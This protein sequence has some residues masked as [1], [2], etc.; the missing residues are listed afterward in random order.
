MIR[1]ISTCLPKLDCLLEREIWAVHQKNHMVVNDKTCCRYKGKQLLERERGR[2]HQRNQIC[3]LLAEQ[4]RESEQCIH[5]HHGALSAIGVIDLRKRTVSAIPRATQRV[6]ANLGMHESTAA[7]PLPSQPLR[8]LYH[9]EALRG[10]LRKRK[11]PRDF[12]AAKMLSR[13]CLFDYFQ[14]DSVQEM[15]PPCYL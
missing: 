7:A 6:K 5:V 1:C 11:Q 14:D 2:R 9:K 8:L 12:V 13:T 15:Q 10:F 3:A 4:A